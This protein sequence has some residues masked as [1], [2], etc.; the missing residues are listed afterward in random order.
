MEEQ[1]IQKENTPTSSPLRLGDWNELTVTRF[2]DNGAY[3]DAGEAGEILMPNAY[4]TPELKEGDT[5]R[6]FVYLDQGERLVATTETPLAK[7]GDFAYLRVAWV[8][9]YGAFLD[10]GLMKDLF[11][12]FR[13]QKKPMRQGEA[14]IVYIYVDTQTDRIVGTAKVDKRLKPAPESY[15]RGREVSLL[16]QQKT[17]LGFKVIVDNAYAGLVYDDQIFGNEPHTGDVLQGTVTA[18]RPD[19][20]LDISLQRI[21]K[22]RFNDFADELLHELEEN[23]GRLP[24]SDNSSPEAINRRFGVSKKTFKRALGTL[25]KSRVINISENEITLIG[26]KKKNAK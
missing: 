24:F 25:Y 23:G 4:L 6:V 16:V 3:L 1:D 17:P 21:G 8:N 15:A 22:A 2:T 12:P 14:Y 9:E 20:R 13:E 10:W 7:V 11:V 18:L 19:G 5:V 26:K